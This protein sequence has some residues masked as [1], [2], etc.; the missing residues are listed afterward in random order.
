MPCFAFAV[1]LTVNW[2]SAGVLPPGRGAAGAPPPP[3]PEATAVGA[4]LLRRLP[5]SACSAAGR[6]CRTPASPSRCGRTRPNVSLQSGSPM[7]SVG[8]HGVQQVRRADEGGAEFERAE[9]PGLADGV[10]DVGRRGP[11]RWLLP[12]L[13]LVRGRAASRSRFTL[14]ASMAYWRSRK[15]RSLFGLASRAASQCSSSTW[16]WVRDMHSRMAVVHER[17]AARRVQLLDQ[18]AGGN[19]HRAAPGAVVR[20]VSRVTEPAARNLSA[21]SAGR[22]V[23]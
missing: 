20:V 4:R 19:G 6:G 7:L 21:L 11:A 17:G 22:P 18:R 14:L 5:R 1:R 23:G 12:V 2:S 15:P 16:K 10:E 9:H 13:E 3:A 8:E